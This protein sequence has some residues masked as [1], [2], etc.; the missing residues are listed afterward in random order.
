[1]KLASCPAGGD[2]MCLTTNGFI[3]EE[4][5]LKFSGGFYREQRREMGSLVSLHR[6]TD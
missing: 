4:K 5:S 6:P 3:G 2:L 1:M